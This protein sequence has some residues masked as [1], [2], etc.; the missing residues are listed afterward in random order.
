MDYSVIGRFEVLI[1]LLC[2]CF[3]GGAND[4]DANL[5]GYRALIVTMSGREMKHLGEG[6]Q[7]TVEVFYAL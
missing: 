7:V 3:E 5:C 2:Y 1:S 4:A 6:F